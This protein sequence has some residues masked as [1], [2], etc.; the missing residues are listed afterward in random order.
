MAANAL[1]IVAGLFLCMA[2]ITFVTYA[3]NAAVGS[4]ALYFVLGLAALGGVLLI[5]ARRA[6]KRE[7]AESGP[8]G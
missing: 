5:A 3:G 7:M 1:F 2:V 4:A 8:E 6:R